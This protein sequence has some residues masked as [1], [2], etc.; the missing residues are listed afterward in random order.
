MARNHCREYLGIWA[1]Q[2]PKGRFST[3]IETDRIPRYIM[4]INITHVQPDS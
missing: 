4:G 1:L 3:K 2:Y